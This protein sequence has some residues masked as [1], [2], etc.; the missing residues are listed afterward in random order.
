MLLHGNLHVIKILNLSLLTLRANTNWPAVF[1]KFYFEFYCALHACTYLKRTQQFTNNT[2]HSNYMKVFI[3][4]HMIIFLSKWWITWQ[5][6]CPNMA[7]SFIN[8]RT[9]ECTKWCCDRASLTLVSIGVLKFHWQRIHFDTKI[10][11]NH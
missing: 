9:L 2:T 5:S 1:L 3:I 11:N 6:T 8:K 7:C 4:N 10:K